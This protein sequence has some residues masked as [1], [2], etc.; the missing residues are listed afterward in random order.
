MAKEEIANVV[1][2]LRKESKRHRELITN[3]D[4][5]LRFLEE[6][7][8]HI[9][10]SARKEAQKTSQL[11]DQLREIAGRLNE[12]A[13]QNANDM[14]DLK[15]SIVEQAASEADRA[16]K[17][18]DSRNRLLAKAM[19]VALSAAGAVVAAVVGGTLTILLAK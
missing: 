19:W 5:R 12:H 14:S 13:V 7:V 11:L 18:A 2:S 16:T 3:M 1:F 17:E 15:V 10:V 4:Q 6:S 9:E 8:R